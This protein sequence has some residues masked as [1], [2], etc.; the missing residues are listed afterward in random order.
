MIA[1]MIVAF[2]GGMVLFSDNILFT[3]C[4][5]YD[6]IYKIFFF[7]CMYIRAYTSM[8]LPT[9]HRGYH[10]KNFYV[11]TLR[12]QNCVLTVFSTTGSGY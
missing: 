5:S 9:F 6:Y 8:T 7:A 1:R 10:V 3:Q 12:K 2:G 11:I 4:R